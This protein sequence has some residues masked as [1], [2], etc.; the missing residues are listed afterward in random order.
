MY[1]PYFFEDIDTGN[2]RTV[3]TEAYIEMLDNVITVDIH[4]DT[5][6]QQDGATSHTSFP[7][8]GLAEKPLRKQHHFT[9]IW[10]ARSPDISPLDYFL[11]GLTFSLWIIFS[12]DVLK[13]V[14]SRRVQTL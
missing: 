11:W 13:R 6:F 4:P 9:P 10:P 5:W 1:G 12:G 14:S 7:R 3:T 2:R 8:N